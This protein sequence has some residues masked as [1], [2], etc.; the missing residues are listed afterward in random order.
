MRERLIFRYAAP[1]IGIRLVI[2]FQKFG[3]LFFEA[4]FALRFERFPSGLSFGRIKH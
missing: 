4:S 2:G 3:V 1:P